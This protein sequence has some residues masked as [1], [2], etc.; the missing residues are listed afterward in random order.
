M[1]RPPAGAT[2]LVGIAVPA[3]SQGLEYPERSRFSLEERT[4]RARHCHPQERTG[5]AEIDQV[6]TIGSEPRGYRQIER[7]IDVG[8]RVALH[9]QI[10]VALRFC[11]VSGGRTE[12]D[13]K[14]EIRHHL[15]KIG[16]ALSDELG[17]DSGGHAV[18]VSERR[19]RDLGTQHLIKE[20]VDRQLEVCHE[21]PLYTLGPLTRRGP[22][23][24][25]IASAIGATMIG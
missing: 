24:D 14:P 23:Y 6:Q 18:T 11:P 20:N 13:E 17:N 16:Q 1:D 10:D 15:G 12:Q 21:A 25:H 22:G 19:E 9:R 7:I 2:E 3:R 5:A 8:Q 4:A